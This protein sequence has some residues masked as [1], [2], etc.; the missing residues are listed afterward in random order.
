M[1]RAVA[2]STLR[3]RVR[4][5][6]DMEAATAR[7]PDSEVT[8]MI[9]DSICRFY[10]LLVAARGMDYYENNST[11]ITDGINT[12]YPLP[13]DFYELLAAEVAIGNGDNTIALM[14]YNRLEHAEL[15]SSTPGWSGEPFAY[16]IRASNIDFLPLPVSGLKITLF[17]I[18]APPTLVNDSDT[19]DG[20]AGWEEIIILDAAIKL[21]RKDDLDASDLERDRALVV[22]EVKGLSAKRDVSQPGRVSDV[23][24][25]WPGWAWRRRRIA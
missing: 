23:R 9:N 8:A 19:I 5:R 20:I 15:V 6:A 21:K 18:P 2:L 10:N 3:D 14:P 25:R 13:A 7:F 22:E 4:K 24:R 1:A 11:V 12:L 17:Y 16:R